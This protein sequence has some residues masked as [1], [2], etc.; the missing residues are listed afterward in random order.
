MA[1]LPA[2]EWGSIRVADR[3]RTSGSE[4]IINMAAAT[5]IK[6]TLILISLTQPSRLD[7]GCLLRCAVPSFA[8]S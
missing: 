7:R 1:K 6:N 2:A 4:A 3:V 5:T 8:N